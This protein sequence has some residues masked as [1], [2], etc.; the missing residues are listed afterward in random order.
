M[1]DPIAD[2]LARIKNALMVRHAEVLIPH[3]N[4]KVEIGRVLKEEGY[5][6]DF[7]ISGEG[8]KKEIVVKL[9][10]STQGA[11]G[12][13]NFKRVSKPSG[14]IYVGKDR[15]P[16]VVTGMGTAILSTSKGIMTG[17][18]A[19]DMGIGGEVICTVV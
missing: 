17:R 19:R 12:I 13:K 6:A 5:I 8:V 2:M 9:K 18:H 15:I 3:S 10:Y 16:R 1:T 7:N 14:R 11:P 4:I